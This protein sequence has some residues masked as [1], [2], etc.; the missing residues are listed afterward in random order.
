MCC[1]VFVVLGIYFLPTLATNMI[2]IAMAQIGTAVTKDWSLIVKIVFKL[3]AVKMSTSKQI[4]VYFC[5][6]PVLSPF[7]YKS[8]TKEQ[9]ENIAEGYLF[10]VEIP[11]SSFELLDGS[12]LAENDDQVL[13][14]G[15]DFI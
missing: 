14:D 7:L 8:L 2:A 15:F 3:L 11:L 10:P 4:K 6:N 13:D 5:G 12:P 1:L 9:K